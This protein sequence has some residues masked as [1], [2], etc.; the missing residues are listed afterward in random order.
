VLFCDV[1]GSD[2]FERSAL[3]LVRWD[4]WVVSMLELLIGL[5]IIRV[6]FV[7]RSNDVLE[8]HL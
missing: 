5:P 1:A 7:E 3:R 4:Y 6:L 2:G 8:I